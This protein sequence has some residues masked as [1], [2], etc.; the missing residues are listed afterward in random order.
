MKLFGVHI[1]TNR[2]L[3]A[4]IQAGAISLAERRAAQIMRRWAGNEACLTAAF[5]A[6]HRLNPEHAFVTDS[7]LEIE[8]RGVQAFADAMSKER[9]EQAA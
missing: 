6:R 3:T 9:G 8:S 7:L 2:D 1:V 4:L 5:A